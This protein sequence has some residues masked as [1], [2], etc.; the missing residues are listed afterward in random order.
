MHTNLLDLILGFDTVHS[1]WWL[2]TGYAKYKQLPVHQFTDIVQICQKHAWHQNVCVYH[3]TY[4]IHFHRFLSNWLLFSI[5]SQ[6]LSAVP[7]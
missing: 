7:C 1:S 4:H 5:W 2:Q 6:A 3:D